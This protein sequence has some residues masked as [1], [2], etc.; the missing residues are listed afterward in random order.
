[1]KFGINDAKLWHYR[2]FVQRVIDGDTV[3]AAIDRGFRDYTVERLRLAGIDAPEL[4]PRKGSSAQRKAEREL[5]LKSKDRLAALIEGKEII[6]KTHKTGKFGR[7]LATLLLPGEPLVDVNEL[8]LDEGLA[9]RYG[10]PRP[11]RN[12]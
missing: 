6:V 5:G 3:V 7:W 9:V 2:A 11:W 12:E 1:M 10:E 4:S 8:L